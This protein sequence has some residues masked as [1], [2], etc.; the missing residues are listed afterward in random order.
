MELFL[1]IIASILKWIFSPFLW[2][3]GIIYSSIFGGRKKYLKD[4]ALAKDQYGNAVGKFAFNSFLIKS[5][6]YKFGNIDETIS[7]CIG[8]NKKLGTLTFLGRFLDK[9]LDLID[10]NHSL[11]SIDE[12]V[13]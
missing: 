5:N 13:N 10:D 6:G 12:N 7:S 8:K 1:F 2:I 3:Y 11:E 4:L 9:I